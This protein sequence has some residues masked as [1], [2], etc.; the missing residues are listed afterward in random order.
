MIARPFIL[1]FSIFC[2]TAAS[3]QAETLA[4]AVRS[5]IS[6]HPDILSLQAGRGSAYAA[7]DVSKSLKR[8][9]LSWTANGTFNK[10]ESS[11][12]KP[13]STSVNATLPIYDGGIAASEK[14]RSLAAAS[15]IDNRFI[16]ALSVI[17]LQTIQTYI[18]V[19]RNRA[20]LKI[21]KR[22]L[23]SLKDIAHRIEIRA[24]NGFGSEA[25]VYEAQATIAAANVQVADIEQQL[26]DAIINYQ[27]L[28]G[29]APQDIQPILIPA[30]GFP[31]DVDDA[32]RLA[33]NYSPKIMAVKYD[34]LAAEASVQGFEAALKPKLDFGL[35]LSYSKEIGASDSGTSDLSG[36]LNF[37]VDL[38][39][40]GAN[41]ARVRQARYNAQASRENAA[42]TAL[43]LEREIRQ[44]WNAVVSS[45]QKHGPLKE[46]AG[47]FRK[48]LNLNLKRFEVGL[49]SLEKILS[50]QNEAE[51]AEIAL[52]NEDYSGRYSLYRILSGTGRLMIA[53]DI[54]VTTLE[55]A[56]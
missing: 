24:A 56:R 9:K 8:P 25:D 26:E 50:L 1:L 36:Q 42:S 16:E 17:G 2:V 19:A 43:N 27:V 47:F 12:T 48:A 40:G 14:R 28:V 51:A 31:L 33:K 34:A 32:I 29:A 49:T 3:A 4:M 18:E 53:L 44:S 5:A 21:T 6:Q 41:K 11:Q 22:G 38:S 20:L 10:Y 37:R 13:V 46:K 15:A 35:G 54:D 55:L 45:V 23:V 30:N 52:L 39:D 7:I